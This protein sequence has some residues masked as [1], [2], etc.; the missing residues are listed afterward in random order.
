VRTQSAV[1]YVQFQPIENPIT[2]SS[3][4]HLP[5]LLLLLLLLPFLPAVPAAALHI[6]TC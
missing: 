6:S 3:L 4:P 2:C 5:L 1:V